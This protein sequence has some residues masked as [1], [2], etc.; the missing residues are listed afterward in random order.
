MAREQGLVRVL[1][2]G[3]APLLRHRVIAGLQSSGVAR[4]VAEAVD[5]AGAL[6]AMRVIPVDVVVLDMDMPGGGL[7]CVRRLL[8]SYLRPVVLVTGPSEREG[9]QAL[10]SLELG[11][12]DFVARP[13]HGEGAMQTFVQELAAKVQAAAALPPR[14]LAQLAS[15]GQ[16]TQPGAQAGE[17]RRPGPAQLAQAAPPWPPG[18]GRST[19]AGRPRAVAEAG[20]RP[21]AQRVVAIGASTGGPAVLEELLSLLPAD[22]PACVLITQHM[23]AG[24]TAML[25]RRLAEHSALPVYEGF[26]GAPL[27]AGLVYVAPGGFHLTVDA[28]RRLHLDTGPPVHFVRPA[29]DVMLASVAQQFGSQ[30]L[31]VILTGMGADGTEGVRRVKQAG[32]RCYVQDPSSCVVAGMPMSVVRAGLADGAMGLRELA[33]AVARWARGN[34]DRP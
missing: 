33:Q 2:A 11:A 8:G 28:G 13:A 32:G 31:A 12:V 15:H 19:P 24:F 3:G 17:P 22:L 27:E 5:C 16:Y 7:A 10:D 1:V 30:V 23:P 6:E 14:V 9:A 18:P 20:R 34:G 4:V 26:E 25:A 21:M 29:V